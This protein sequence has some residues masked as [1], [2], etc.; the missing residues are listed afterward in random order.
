MPRDAYSVC[1]WEP[2]LLINEKYRLVRR[3]GAG[4]MGEVWAAHHEAIDRHVAI[5]FPDKELV[6]RPE[7]RERFL[8]EA[9]VLGRLHHPNIVDVLDFGTLDDD[10]LFMVVEL[11]DGTP[12]DARLHDVGR[13]PPRIAVQIAKELCH[14][15]AY[16]HDAGVIHRDLKPG[17]VF[18]HSAAG[19]R[20]LVKIIDFGISKILASDENVSITN[21]GVVVGTPAYMSYEQ[22]RALPD[23]DARSDLWNVGILLY[24]M[25]SGLP[26][27]EATSYSAT[28]AKIVSEDPPALSD[29]GVVAPA[30]L[31]AI[32]RRCLDREREHR[33]Q[34]ADEL[35]LALESVLPSLSEPPGSARVRFESLTDLPSIP[36]PSLTPVSSSSSLRIYS[37]CAR[38]VG[39]GE[40]T[41]PPPLL[42]SGN[43][44]QQF[45]PPAGDRSSRAR[46]LAI[47][48]GA[49]AIVAATVGTTLYF[50]G[51]A[52]QEPA[53]S[54][55]NGA[56]YPANEAFAEPSVRVQAPA[57]SVAVPA[58]A[59]SAT[60]SAAASIAMPPPVAPSSPL[61]SHT[62]KTDTDGDKKRAPRTL[63]DDPGF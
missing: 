51:S 29:W 63:V 44:T 5:K 43:G 15:L 2:G 4:G 21:T 18:L 52:Q 6:G 20:L 11:L 35:R 61:R 16:A 30:A 3:V 62:P 23:I 22:T 53:A 14:G 31:E 37:P 60:A 7:I 57:A 17:N 38:T 49:L 55:P 45:A 26:P 34:S 41:V 13:L 59:T 9:R 47:A 32:I 46:L 28:V 33:F 19:G 8:A 42:E 27:F 24:E 40:S 1:V 54:P 25:L 48:A 50:V 10:G 39:S 58:P 36:P 56:A 12:L